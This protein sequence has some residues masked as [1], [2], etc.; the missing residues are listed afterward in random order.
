MERV[1]L[2]PERIAKATCPTDK[3]QVFLFDSEVPRLAVRITAGSKSFVF[4]G[5]LNRVT[6]RVTIGGIGNW[7]VDS[8]RAEARRLQTLIDQDIDPRELERE[9]AEAKRQA[10]A[11]REE[12]N[13]TAERRKRY[14]LRALCEAYA[15]HLKEQGKN[16]SSSDTLSA[17]RC[18]VF[19]TEHADT[20][21]TEVTAQAIAEIVRK[22]READ[23]KRTAGALRN[24][25][26]AAYNAARRSPFDSAFNSN[27]IAFGVTA[28]P[29]EAVPAIQVRRGDRTLSIAELKSYLDA[30]G[31]SPVDQL[32]R[33]HLYAGGQRMKQLARARVADFDADTGTLRLLDPKGKREVA[34]E[35]YLPL[36]D[37]ARK[38]ALTEAKGK[39]PASKVFKC[40][41]RAAGNRIAEI[42]AAM[43]APGFDTRDLRRTCETMLASMG[44]TKETRAHLLSHGLGGVQDAH[45]DRYEYINE[46][47]AALS[48]WEARLNEIQTGEVGNK[49]NVVSLTKKTA[50]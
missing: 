46:K 50:A 45:Y 3:K 10:H 5:K 47:R 42:C 23:K 22:V 37:R 38:I 12:R 26:V 9:K 19:T 16:K 30:L 4:E 36:A 2:T 8:A 35:H 7:T 32:L 14:T 13:A 29:A 48:A 28:N 17:F 6:I 25:L 44:I 31:D 27:L 20:P 21:A 39:D 11:E 34:R 40:G 33:V 24:Y 15:N 41:A 18:H 1:R 49:Q 43:K